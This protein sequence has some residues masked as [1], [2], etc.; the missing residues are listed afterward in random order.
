MSEQIA[1]DLCSAEIAESASDGHPESGE[2]PFW[3]SVLS[4]FYFSN[5]FNSFLRAL[6]V[7]MELIVVNNW[8]LITEM[9]VERTSVWARA[10]FVL[11]YFVSVVVVMNVLTAF[12]LE[13]FIS[14]NQRN[15]VEIERILKMTEQIESSSGS[16]NDEV[17]QKAP[18]K[19]TNQIEERMHAVIGMFKVECVCNR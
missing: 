10:Y 19:K 5:N 16:P 17:L 2:H 6:V 1:A 18:R 3:C 11:V 14:Q 7:Q 4:T 15:E 9:Y 12:V 8:H 13:A